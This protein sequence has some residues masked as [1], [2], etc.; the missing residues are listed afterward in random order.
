VAFRRK[1]SKHRLLLWQWKRA[2]KEK[3]EKAKEAKVAGGQPLEV[4]RRRLIRQ[5]PPCA[6][7]PRPL[8]DLARSPRSRKQ[9]RRSADLAEPPPPPGERGGPLGQR[10]LGRIGDI[11]KGRS[12]KN[13]KRNLASTVLL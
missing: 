12:L 13:S 7:A 4:G 9:L 6:A 1:K 5:A 10:G 3:K 11:R 2:K 8:G